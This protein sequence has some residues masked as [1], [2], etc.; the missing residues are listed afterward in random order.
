MLA[1]RYQPSA[2][3]SAFVEDFWLY[4]GYVSAHTRERILPCGTFELV[5][6]L[7]EDE[8]RIYSSA[9]PGQYR[10]FSGA[11]VSGPYAGYFGSDA[12]EEFSVMGV[13]FRP[14]GAFPFLGM[15]AGEL[16]DTHVDLAVLWKGRA[17]SLRAELAETAS[18][19]GRF[20]LLEQALIRHLY[21]PLEHHP[22]VAAALH[23]FRQPAVPARTRELACAV[24]LSERRFIDVFRAE[25]GMT[26]KVFSRV[27]RFQRV[28]AAAHAD[29]APDWAELAL[30][31]G[32]FDQSHLIRDF[33]LFSGVSPADYVR[34]LDALRSL[35]AHTKPNHLALAE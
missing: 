24:N 21:R 1:V 32:Y 18:A 4:D 29:M 3:L 7:R 23:A 31:C 27:Q 28:L 33:L 5:F 20:R 17:S 12:V 30:A 26:P 9:R 13:H 15:P 11:V 35:G 6:N 10:R 2:F 16:A 22:A 34:R 19:A 14:G 8:L 25:V